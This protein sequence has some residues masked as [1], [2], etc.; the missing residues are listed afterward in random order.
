MET[1][2]WVPCSEC[3]AIVPYV[4]GVLE[5]YVAGHRV[6]CPLCK[7]PVLWWKAVL[8]GIEKHFHFGQVMAMAGCRTLL[9]E[10]EVPPEQTVEVNLADRGVPDN[11]E[12]VYMNLTGRGGVWP[13]MVHGNDAIRDPL[14]AKF[15]LY[16]R[17]HKDPA[18]G[19]GHGVGIMATWFVRSPDDTVVRHLVDAAR[20]YQAERFDA[21]VV[22]ANVA[23]EASLTP[24]LTHFFE[25]Y[26][27]KGHVEEM[28][29]KGATYSHQLNVLMNVAAEVLG[30]PRLDDHIRGLLNRLRKLRNDIAHEGKCK[31]QT[32]TDAAEHLAAAF[33]MVRYA[34]VLGDHMV[35]PEWRS[36][37]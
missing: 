19:L 22:P 4:L 27:G 14:G 1:A 37:R 16:G 13:L 15:W 8:E 7:R 11:A 33:F 24:V 21:V 31:G 5:A 29:E 35:A 36:R 17:P 3:G 2:P 32:R 18:E 12:I 23:A 28:L 25:R 6:P 10:V 20:H 34:K 9:F 30:A 26:A